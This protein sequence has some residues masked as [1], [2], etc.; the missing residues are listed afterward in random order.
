[1]GG[2]GRLSLDFFKI[3]ELHS[4]ELGFGLGIPICF[5]SF[6]ER[7]KATWNCE[8]EASQACSVIPWHVP[9]PKRRV[10]V[11]LPSQLCMYLSQK[12]FK[13][14]EAFVSLKI[15]LCKQK[16]H[17]TSQ[18]CV[19][20]CMKR[21]AHTAMQLHVASEVQNDFKTQRAARYG[22]YSMHM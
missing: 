1:M 13:C 18:I 20:S 8:C 9:K 15:G 19:S 14:R 21:S 17:I 10:S 7:F 11:V 16:C 2:F 3:L 5:I 6:G 22:A 4:R 12:R